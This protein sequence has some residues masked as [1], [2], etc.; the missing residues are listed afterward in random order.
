[1]ML[2]KEVVD[3]YELDLCFSWWYDEWWSISFIKFLSCR[4]VFRKFWKLMMVLAKGNIQLD[5]DRIV[6]HFVPRLKMSSP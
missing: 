5:S 6:W 4:D 3:I 1:M 2:R